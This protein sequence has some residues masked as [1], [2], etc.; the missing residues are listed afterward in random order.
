MDSG[1]GRREDPD[2]MQQVAKRD[3]CLVRCLLHHMR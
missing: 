1:Y 3:D 2:E